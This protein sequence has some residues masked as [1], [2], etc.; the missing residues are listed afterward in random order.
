MRKIVLMGVCL[1]LF[2]GFGCATSGQLEQKAR[3]HDMRA[4]AAASVRD[5]D[6]A[7]DEKAEA[8]RLHAKAVKKAYKEGLSSEV[9]LPQAPSQV[10]HE[11]Q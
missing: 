8:N 11:H 4:D 5:Y 1:S 6:R 10:P 3:I 9:A 7:A 2:A